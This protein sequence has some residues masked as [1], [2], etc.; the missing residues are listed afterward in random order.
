MFYDPLL[1]DP[2]GFKARF[3]GF[4]AFAAKWIFIGLMLRIG[5]GLIA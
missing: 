1:D 3:M 2:D 5:W 4:A